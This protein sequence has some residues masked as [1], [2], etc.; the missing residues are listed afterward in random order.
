MQQT[1]SQIVHLLQS[2]ASILN[3][4]DIQTAATAIGQYVP[5]V[6]G[7]QIRLGDDCA[8]IFDGDGYLL[9]AAEG[10]WPQLV[11]SDPW[12]A[13]WCAVM[14]NL[15]DIAAM[16][17]SAIAVVDALWSRSQEETQQIWAGMRAAATAYGVPIVGGHTNCHSEYSGLA[18]AVLGRASQLITS[19]EA[20]PGDTLMM[21]INMAG[22]YYGDYPFWNAATMAE[23]AMLRSHLSKL[24]DLANANLCSAGKDISMGGLAGTLL[25]LCEASGCGALLDLNRVPRPVGVPWTKWLTSFPSYGF[26]LSVPPNNVA[27][28]K[29]LFASNQVVCQTVGEITPM[30]SVVL[31]LQDERRLLWDLTRSLTGFGNTQIQQND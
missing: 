22:V 13:G 28:V 3:K 8:A 30:T 17:G 16:G 7:S 10:I 9:L 31:Q 4:Q 18:V 26:L 11:L 23:P 21:V 20:S 14:V 27:A 2:A 24:T 29:R 12:F 25:M 5:G 6:D 15:S 19:F 1:L